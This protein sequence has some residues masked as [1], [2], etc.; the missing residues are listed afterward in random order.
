MTCCRRCDTVRPSDR[1][2]GEAFLQISLC[3]MID[4]ALGV[5]TDQYRSSRGLVQLYC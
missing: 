5:L 3:R 4:T 1:C 2:W